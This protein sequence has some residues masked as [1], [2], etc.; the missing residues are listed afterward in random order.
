MT[1]DEFDA[2][3]ERLRVQIATLVAEREELRAVVDMG[4][5]AI[6]RIEGGPLEPDEGRYGAWTNHAKAV[7]KKGEA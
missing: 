3:I 5:Y 4:I 7:L 6:E 2:L 1:P